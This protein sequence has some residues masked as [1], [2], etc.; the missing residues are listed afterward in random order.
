MR[1]SNQFETREALPFEGN[2][3]KPLVRPRRTYVTL[4]RAMRLGKTPG[5]KGCAK[6]SE[7]IPLSDECHERFKRLLEHEKAA[8]AEKRSSAPATPKA[9]AMPALQQKANICPA[10]NPEQNEKYFWE[11]DENTMCWKRLFTSVGKD[12][13]F[14]S[15]KITSH[16]F[17]EWKCRGRWSTYEDD[18]Q[19]GSPNRRISP[20]SWTG[21]TWFFP[22]E[23]VVPR[24]LKSLQCK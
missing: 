13:P 21:V 2:A 16:R 5:C 12:V 15:D 18:W 7:G 11:F 24:L 3:P 10:T 9:A 23:P 19:H 6:N 1:N 22:K 8:E 17:T 20:R 4:K 14:D